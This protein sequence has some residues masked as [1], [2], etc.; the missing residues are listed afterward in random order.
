MATGFNVS[1]IRDPGSPAARADAPAAQPAVT[2][3]PLGQ[4]ID[5]RPA[6]QPV[7]AR[8]VV[9]ASPRTFGR[10]TTRSSGKRGFNRK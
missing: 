1:L 3:R 10:T 4:L 2:A 8:P 9:V 7:A 5:A 6:A